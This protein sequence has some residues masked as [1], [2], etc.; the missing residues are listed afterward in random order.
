MIS[1]NNHLNFSVYMHPPSDLHLFTPHLFV[2]PF[3]SLLLSVL[4]SSRPPLILL[5]SSSHSAHIIDLFRPQTR[6]STDPE[7]VQQQATHL[8][9][10]NRQTGQELDR[11]FKSK[12]Q[13]EEDTTKVEDQIEAQ[14]RAIQNRIDELEP[15]KLRAYND[16]LSK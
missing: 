14:Y 16:L 12:K 10:K 7:D 8:A 4:L 9:E 3:L 5:S 6:T 1:P 11:V 2:T 15:G 13:K